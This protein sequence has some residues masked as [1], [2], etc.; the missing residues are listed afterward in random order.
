MYVHVSPPPPSPRAQD[1]G[2]LLA[3]LVRQ[4]R[5]DHPELS[6]TDVQQAFQVARG[7]L[8]PELGGLPA[9]IGIV[10]ALLVAGVLAFLLFAKQGSGD[11]PFMMP[12]IAIAALIGVIG[13]IFAITVARR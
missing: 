8:K 12:L 6:R 1:L 2:H 11:S 13:V 7:L 5:A 9:T 4:Y 10:L 3:E